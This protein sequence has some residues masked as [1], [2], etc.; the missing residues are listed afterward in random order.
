MKILNREGEARSMR[1][2]GF[3]RGQ[4]VLRAAERNF[5]YPTYTRFDVGFRLVREVEK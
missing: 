1:G 3:G 4:V 5:Y 2:G